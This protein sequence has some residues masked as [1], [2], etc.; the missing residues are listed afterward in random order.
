M[1]GKVTDF[2]L[3]LAYPQACQI[4]EQS[5]ENLSDG[6]ACR[7]CWEKTRIF[8]GAETL[9]GKCGRF[10]QSKPTNSQ[11]FC[12]QCDE[13]FYDSASAIG[14]YEYA[15]SASV[16]NLKRE[17]FVAKRLQKLFVSRFENSAFQEVT[18]IIPVPLSKKR[19][20]ERSFN[21]AATLAEILAAQTRITLDKKTLV[22]QVHTLMHR[23]TMDSKAREAT[24]KNAFEI[25]RQNF[26]KD[27]NILLVDD[28]FTSGATVSNCAKVLK[29][30]GAG[31]VYVLTIARAA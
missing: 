9:C 21:Q 26:I 29:E 2:V 6:V 19:F 28:V 16:L 14:I 18:K 13:H 4:C 11:T 10:L 27:E 23:A 15:L 24:V 20:L 30:K 22:R 31:K 1:L 25:K 5:V 17:P 8:S 3:T 12:H 7:A